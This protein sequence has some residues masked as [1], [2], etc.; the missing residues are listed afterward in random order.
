MAP[1]STAIEISLLCGLFIVLSLWGVVWDISSGLLSS[2]I[3][4]IMLLA[5]CAMMA[6]IFLLIAMAQLVQAG[7]VPV[8]AFLRPEPK[9]APAAKAP[10]AAAPKP[11]AAAALTT[12]TSASSAA[13]AAP[14][15]PAAPAPAAAAAK[16][17]TPAATAT[18]PATP[19]K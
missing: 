12:A 7:L 8:P 19:E 11:V 4:G 3:D 13:P 6:G 2:G 18:P 14:A 16:P 17:T 5:V 15:K 9:P 1:K 10:A